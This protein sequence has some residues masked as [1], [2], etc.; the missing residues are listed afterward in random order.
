[1]YQFKSTKNFV[2]VTNGK[3]TCFFSLDT[4]PELLGRHLR[5]IEELIARDKN[6]P[7]VVAWSLLNEPETTTDE[8]VPYFEKVFA[9]AL[10]ISSSISRRWRPRSSRIRGPISVNATSSAIL[11]V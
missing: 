4:I 3:V 8:S 6:H 1:M 11:S 7:S 2:D 5:D 9:H 10:A